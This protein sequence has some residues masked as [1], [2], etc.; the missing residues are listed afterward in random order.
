MLRCVSLL[1]EKRILRRL[2]KLA[3]RKF[4]QLKKRDKEMRV[5]AGEDDEVVFS[6]DE[7]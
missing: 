3:N 6:K 7:L 1:S 2:R 5:A 4:K